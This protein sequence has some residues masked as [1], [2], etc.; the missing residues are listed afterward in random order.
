MR[1][2]DVSF[3]STAVKG[4]FLKANTSI[5][6]D[7]YNALVTALEKI[8]E[9]PVGRRV[10]EQIIKNHDAARATGMPICQD[11]GMAVVF[12]DIGQDVHF[13]GGDLVQAV[14][15]GV[16]QAYSEGFFRRSLVRDP[17]F[18]RTN[19][20]T[21]TPAVI[22]TRIV[23]GERVHILITPKGFGSE[24]MSAVKFLTPAQGPEG[25]RDF[26]M[27]TVKAAGPNPCPPTII[28]VGVG[29]TME[30]AA[31]MAKR[32]TLYTVGRRNPDAK[33]G[34]LELEI[35]E[36][37]NN[38]GIGPGGLGGRV[39]CLDVHIDFAPGH[40]A[41]TPVAVNICCHAARHAEITL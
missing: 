35:L 28:G 33:Y 11:T 21:N 39:T 16:E 3:V 26:I 29:G 19:T 9:S 18:D 1:E 40:I 23:R 7:V 30:L 6:Q 27:D 24:N 31:I 36:A 17:L 34:A 15:S 38:T 41:G 22:H 14:N 2:I 12:A 5:G 20:G 10:L 37:V 4:L 32:G 25:V 8:E 13:T